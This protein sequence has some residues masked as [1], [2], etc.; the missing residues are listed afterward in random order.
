MT[1]RLHQTKKEKELKLDL[2]L[3]IKSQS[4]SCRNYLEYVIKKC[5]DPSLIRYLA[6]EIAE[7]KSLSYFEPLIADNLYSPSHVLEVLTLSSN[8]LT[9]ACVAFN[10]NTPAQ[11]VLLLKKDE[12]EFVRLIASKNPNLPN[13]GF[14]TQLLERISHFIDYLK[15]LLGFN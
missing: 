2:E 15:C 7:N 12:N 8:P 3:Y 14:F 6:I 5:K 4:K 1:E 9:R 10:L 13:S 11:S